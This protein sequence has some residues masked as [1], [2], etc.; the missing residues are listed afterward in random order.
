MPLTL[1]F[2]TSPG[3]LNATGDSDI[4]FFYDRVAQYQKDRVLKP[5]KKLIEIVMLCTGDKKIPDK[6]DI[7]FRPLWQESAKD[8]AATMMSQS[9]A[10]VAWITAG[11]LSAEE[12]A[13]G[14]WSTGKYQPDITVDFA[15]RE[16]QEQAVAAPVKQADLDAINPDSPNYK[17]SQLDPNSSHYVEPPGGPAVPG[18]LGSPGGAQPKPNPFSKMDANVARRQAYRTGSRPS[19]DG[20][21]R[22]DLGWGDEKLDYSPDQ[23]RASDGKFGSGSAESKAQDDVKNGRDFNNSGFKSPTEEKAYAKAYTNALRSSMGLAPKVET[24]GA[25]GADH[26]SFLKAAE[27]DRSPTDNKIIDKWIGIGYEEING[28]ARAGKV[29]ADVKKLDAVVA[30]SVAPETMTVYRGCLANENMKPGAVF[31]DK[32]FVATSTDEKKALGF[33]DYEHSLN[34]DSALVRI[35]VPKGKNAAPLPYN[36]RDQKDSE[37]LLPRKSKFKITSVSHE[38]KHLIVNAEVL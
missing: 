12:V 35:T 29:T 8:K 14:H 31:S 27:E 7:D 4:R 3:G 30:K 13:A 37:I 15:A 6:W 34:H 16:K 5:L 9:T 38:G 32:G 25:Q 21:P 10:D 17:G 18:A 1:L 22:N 36:Q 19:S 20:R 24:A 23:E 33:A 11:V 26:A 2:G 28:A